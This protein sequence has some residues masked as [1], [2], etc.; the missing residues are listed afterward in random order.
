MEVVGR[1]GAERRGCVLGERR[2]GGRFRG[3][4]V[5]ERGNSRG[6]PLLSLWLSPMERQ[7]EGVESFCL[8]LGMVL[9]NRK[10]AFLPTIQLYD[11]EKRRTYLE[12]V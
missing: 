1:G 3:R 4:E 8:G 2:G 9:Q 10:I 12:G 5:V 11:I 7:L 6:D